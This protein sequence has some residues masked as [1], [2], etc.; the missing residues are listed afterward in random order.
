[1]D[2]RILKGMSLDI[3]ENRKWLN[4]KETVRLLQKKVD[5]SIRLSDVARLIADK[6]IKPSI[7]FRTPVFAREVKLEEKPLSY[8]LAEIETALSCNRHLLSEETIIAETLVTHA[9]PINQ[10]IIRIK[11]V[12]SVLPVGITLHEAERIYSEEEQLSSPCRSLYDVKGIIVS[13]LDKYYQ[14]VTPFDVQRELMEL[15]QL[16][17]AQNITD[18]GFLNGHIA[19]LKEIRNKLEANSAYESL[20]P[21]ISL[22]PN[23]YLA[24]KREDIN[25]FIHSW[26]QPEKKISSKTANAQSEFIYGLIRTQYGI[27]VAENPRRH[28][29]GKAG[30]IRLAFEKEGLSL[31]SGNT[32]SGWIKDIIS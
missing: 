17:K 10:N 31:P 26:C 5:A 12:W 23:A 18:N 20:M 6:D 1:M 24:L 3:L 11:D 9:T 16:T 25:D 21:C 14:I 29:E 32:V 8:L 27:D 28:I 13:D 4:L 22:P 15:V 2:W 19:K 7:F 30:V